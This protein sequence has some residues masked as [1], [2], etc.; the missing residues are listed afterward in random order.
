MDLKKRIIG[1]HKCERQYHVKLKVIPT[2]GRSSFCGGSLISNKWILTAAH[3]LKPN[4]SLSVNLGGDQ[5]LITAKPVIYTD[6]DTS[7]SSKVKSHDIMLLQLP[8]SFNIT[9][10]ALPDCQ[11]HPKTF[12]IA[13]HAATIGGTDGTRKPSIS[14]DLHCAEINA[15]DC[16]DLKN[17]LKEKYPHGYKIK[18]YQHWFCGQ[19]PGVDICFGDSGGGVVHKDKIY[20][21]ISFLGDPE[22]VCRKPAAFMDLCN[23]EYAS[24]IKR[25]ILNLKGVNDIK[26]SK[27]KDNQKNEV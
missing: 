5:V 7:D 4:A 6:K 20:G 12:E 17:T 21:V 13:G 25:N 2:V 18:L 15:V 19:T 3:C 26:A 14:P 16:N 27:W 22:Y 23:P 24:W 9:P 11:T 10:V 1:G 8:R